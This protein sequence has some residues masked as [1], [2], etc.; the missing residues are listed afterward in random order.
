MDLGDFGE[1]LRAISSNSLVPERVVVVVPRFADLLFQ[2]AIEQTQAGLASYLEYITMQRKA[3][4]EKTGELQSHEFFATVLGIPIGSPMEAA[5][6]MSSLDQS[7]RR[8]IAGAVLAISAAEA[9]VNE[10]APDVGGWSDNEDREPLV[11]K[12]KLVAEKAS[13]SL[14][15]GREPFQTLQRSVDYRN[16][17]VHPKPEERQLDLSTPRAPGRDL[18]LRARETCLAVRKSLLMLADVLGVS[19]PPYLA[20]C[21]PGNFADD[22]A[23]STAVVMTGLPDDPD[24]PKVGS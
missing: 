16:D 9:Q 4:R 18:S 17:L 23:W 20:Y 6:G 14:D 1:V 11:K 10:W 12:M 3:R 7:L 21:P 2:G 13:Q 24:F 5:L 15:I 22:E 8:S 19:R